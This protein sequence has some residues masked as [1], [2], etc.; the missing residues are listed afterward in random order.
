MMG[1]LSLSEPPKFLLQPF[2]V[3]LVGDVEGQ[4]THVLQALHSVLIVAIL[5]VLHHLQGFRLVQMALRV[6]VSLQLSEKRRLQTLNIVGE[7][8]VQ[9]EAKEADVVDRRWEETVRGATAQEP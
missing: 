1:L 2:L 3:E 7:T 5:E 8:V 4:A 6:D 9:H